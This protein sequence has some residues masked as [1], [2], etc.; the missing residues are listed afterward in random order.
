M[1]IH[2]LAEKSGRSVKTCCGIVGSDDGCHEFTV[3]NGM[4]SRLE[5]ADRK[6]QVTCKRCLSKMVRESLTCT[7]Q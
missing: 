2:F 4:E 6:Q 1:K 5:Y 7:Q 3:M